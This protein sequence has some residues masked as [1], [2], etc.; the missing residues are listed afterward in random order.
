ME[1]LIIVTLVFSIINFLLLIAI[2]GT[3]AKLIKYLTNNWNNFKVP[4]GPSLKKTIPS[5]SNW[6]GLK[7]RARNWDGVKKDE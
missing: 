5:D 1:I 7:Q 3:L 4:M 2:S 6:D